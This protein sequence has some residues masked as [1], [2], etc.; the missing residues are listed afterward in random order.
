MFVSPTADAAAS[1]WEKVEPVLPTVATVAVSA[2]PFGSKVSLAPADRGAVVF[3]RIEVSPALTGR[4]SVT[5]PA[6]SGLSSGLAP[7]LIA[8][9]WLDT[10]WLARC[11]GVSLATRSA[12]RSAKE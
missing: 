10:S 4:V 5:C 2:V 6:G 12:A 3:V 9:D 1:V 11:A 7:V 8:G